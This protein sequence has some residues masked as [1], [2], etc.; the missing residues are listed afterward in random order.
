MLNGI[1]VLVDPNFDDSL[2]NALKNLH[3]NPEK[4]KEL[5]Q[6]TIDQLK[7]ISW[8]NSAKILYN[9]FLQVKA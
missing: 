4:I 6:K 2:Y 5:E 8:K 1:G 7:K 3:L 9:L